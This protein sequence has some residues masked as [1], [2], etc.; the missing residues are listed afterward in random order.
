MKINIDYVHNLTD[1][2]FLHRFYFGTQ[3][4]DLRRYGIRPIEFLPDSTP[5]TLY[6]PAEVYKIVQIIKSIFPEVTEENKIEFSMLIEMLAG[7]RYSNQL[8]YL[9]FN[10]LYI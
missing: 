10:D 9:I 3:N 1:R 7:K 6:E 8:L 5:E 4:F 2:N